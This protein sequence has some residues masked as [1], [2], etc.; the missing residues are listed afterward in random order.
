ML[1][2]ALCLV[3][4]LAFIYF[5]VFQIHFTIPS[6]NHR[7]AKELMSRPFQHSLIEGEY[8]GTDSLVA[9]NT[10]VRIRRL[11]TQAGHPSRTSAAYPTENRQLVLSLQPLLNRESLWFLY[12]KEVNDNDEY[13]INH[14]DIVHFRH[15]N[16]SGSILTTFVL[17]SAKVITITKQGSELLLSS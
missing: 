12:K 11:A 7:Q 5:S 9:N 14:S 16:M 2:R 3:D 1:C 4:F 8:S 15:D 13:I 17:R 6:R 10:V